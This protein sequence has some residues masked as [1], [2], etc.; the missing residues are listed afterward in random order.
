MMLQFTWQGLQ[1][2]NI[3]SDQA[4]VKLKSPVEAN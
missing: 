1:T 3:A 2:Q 4:T